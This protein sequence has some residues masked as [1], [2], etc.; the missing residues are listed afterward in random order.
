VSPTPPPSTS[1][2]VTGTYS[3]QPPAPQAMPA[4]ATGYQTGSSEAPDEGSAGSHVSGGYSTG[5]E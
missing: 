1:S 2:Q 3:S 5:S 4:P